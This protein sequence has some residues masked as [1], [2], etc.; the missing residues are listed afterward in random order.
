[1]KRNNEDLNIG[2]E[3][4]NNRFFMYRSKDKFIN[5]PN[6]EFYNKSLG[7]WENFNTLMNQQQY[8]QGQLDLTNPHSKHL[9][10][11]LKSSVANNRTQIENG[12]PWMENTMESGDFIKLVG[13]ETS[14]EKDESLENKRLK[15]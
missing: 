7:K 12:S 1:M 10:K 11:R 13:T 8:L 15:T 6:M 5:K 3:S 4:Q 14:I 9:Q 2:S